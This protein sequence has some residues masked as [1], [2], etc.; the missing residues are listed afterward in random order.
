MSKTYQA[1][2]QH[3]HCFRP[4]P[5]KGSKPPP[6][7]DPSFVNLAGW[8]TPHPFGFETNTQFLN[9]PSVN[10]LTSTNNAAPFQTSCP[11]VT[12]TCNVKLFQ[13]PQPLRNIAHQH[14]QPRQ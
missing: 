5:P 3:P 2:A 11:N 13:R 4:P 12:F 6:A 9:Q 8:L 1:A 10:V 14:S 7:L